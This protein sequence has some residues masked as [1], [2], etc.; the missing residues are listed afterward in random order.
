MA[1]YDVTLTYEKT[2]RIPNATDNNDALKKAL[3]EGDGI[4]PRKEDVIKTLVVSI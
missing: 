2:F 1:S 4:P 3:R